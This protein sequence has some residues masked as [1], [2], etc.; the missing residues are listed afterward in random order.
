MQLIADGISVNDIKKILINDI[1]LVKS[2]HETGRQM[3][4]E[5]GKYAPTFGMVGALIGLVQMLAN[6]NEA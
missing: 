6:L 5:M 4:A 3:F 2:R 1:L